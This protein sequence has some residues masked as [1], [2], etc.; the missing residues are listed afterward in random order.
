VLSF[1]LLWPTVVDQNHACLYAG[2]YSGGFRPGPGG[3]HKT[4]QFCSRPFQFHGHPGFFAKITE[5]SDFFE[6]PNFRKVGKF[7]A[8]IECPKTKSASASGSFAPLTPHQG[9]CPWT[10]L[11]AP[12]QSSVIGSRYRARHGA[13]PPR[14]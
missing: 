14:Y 1:Q 13:V 7:A 12:P 6:L 5:I 4:P 9:L 8:S 11:G 3:G 10:P 2:I